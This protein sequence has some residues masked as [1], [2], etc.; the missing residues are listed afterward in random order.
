LTHEPKIYD[1]LENF[2]GDRSLIEFVDFSE[3]IARQARDLIREA[4]SLKYALHTN[5]AIHLISAQH[6]GVSDFFTY[7]H[8]LNKF[9]N[10]L[11]YDIQEPYLLSPKLPLVFP[12]EPDG[13]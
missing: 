1:A 8:K 6:V 10:I 4:I 13:E 3:L 11:R 7:D 2:W 12:S 5:D 9:S